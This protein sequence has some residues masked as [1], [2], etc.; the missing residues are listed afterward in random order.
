MI[1]DIYLPIYSPNDFDTV[2]KNEKLQKY[3]ISEHCMSPESDVL[4]ELEKYF[5]TVIH[6]TY[7]EGFLIGHGKAA[8]IKIIEEKLSLP[9][10]LTVAI[11]DSLNDTDMLKYA[12]VS[13]AMENAPAEVKNICDFVTDTTEKNGVAKAIFKLID[14]I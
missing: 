4:K 9:H 3:V 14:Q 5:T 2:F 1:N 6:P 13:V 8:L 11:G 10:E 7:A 12:A